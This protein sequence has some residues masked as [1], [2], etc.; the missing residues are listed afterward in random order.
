MRLEYVDGTSYG[1][2]LDSTWRTILVADPRCA[3]APSFRENV[4]R[5]AAE[6]DRQNQR[7]EPCR[8]FGAI[9]RVG[10][11]GPRVIC[12]FPEADNAWA[13]EGA[14]ARATWAQVVALADESDEILPD[15]NA[16]AD[17]IDLDDVDERPPFATAVRAGDRFA[18]CAFP[19]AKRSWAVSDTKRRRSL[20]EVRAAAEAARPSSNLSDADVEALRSFGI[21]DESID[22]LR[23]INPER[24]QIEAILALLRTRARVL[25]MIGGVMSAA[26]R[27]L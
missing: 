18:I 20:D 6:L 23:T 4:E 14:K 15:G 27:G 24:E 3:N 8:R 2:P 19:K 10:E 25:D 26:I 12:A 11:S 21:S 5:L 7:V 16:L 9:Y 17:L 13:I 22:E 1:A